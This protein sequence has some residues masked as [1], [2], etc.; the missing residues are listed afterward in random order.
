MATRS[1]IKNALAEA[2]QMR[3]HI[4]RHYIKEAVRVFLESLPDEDVNPRDVA[5]IIR[6]YE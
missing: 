1:T 3:T 4:P 6:D 5:D 2:C